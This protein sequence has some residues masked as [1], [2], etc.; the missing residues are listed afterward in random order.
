MVAWAVWGVI[1]IVCVAA[2][3]CATDSTL[4]GQRY[5][6]QQFVLAPEGGRATSGGELVLEPPSQTL[7]KDGIEIS[8]E[9][10]SRAY[11]HEFLKSP[12][13]AGKRHKNPYPD[14]L[15][16]FYVKVSNHSD[17]RVRIDPSRFVVLDDLNAQHDLVGIEYAAASRG[18]SRQVHSLSQTGGQYAPG[19]YSAPF[20][21]ANVLL[22]RP[23][24]GRL[25]A[26][27]ALSLPGGMV[28][29]NV[30]YDGFVA[31]DRPRPGAK[32]F[33]FLMPHVQTHFDAKD[34]AGKF[35]DFEFVFGIHHAGDEL[36]TVAP[37][38]SGASEGPPAS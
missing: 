30:T 10:A 12:G 23:A 14:Q 9:Y 37:S 20:E 29:H 3:G 36:P 21:V 35:L 18:V 38:E 33:R 11:L 16:V 19:F 27:R 22:E 28:Y 4:L 25:D 2:T 17:Q 15:M 34:E 6:K 8:V 1:G 13:W 32:Q 31:F 5:S 24:R 26:M 7:Q